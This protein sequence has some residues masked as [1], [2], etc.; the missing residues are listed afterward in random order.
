MAVKK[1]QVK[2]RDHWGLWREK[3]LKPLSLQYHCPESDP[4]HLSLRWH[5]C[6]NLVPTGLPSRHHHVRQGLTMTVPY[7]SFGATSALWQGPHSQTPKPTFLPCFPYLVLLSFWMSSH[8]SSDVLDH[9]G[10]FHS[11]SFSDF[12]HITHVESSQNVPVSPHLLLTWQ[13]WGRESGQ[14][15]ERHGPLTSD[16][17][18]VTNKLSDLK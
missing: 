16:F 14:H 12:V 5:F 7:S 2:A 11:G 15:R 4:S 3:S 8:F 18:S 9:L 1:S 17:G 6:P 10:P 13:S